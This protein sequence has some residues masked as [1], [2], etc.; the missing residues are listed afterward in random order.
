MVCKHGS[1]V[2]NDCVTHK[3]NKDITLRAH[4]CPISVVSVSVSIVLESTVLEHNLEGFCSHLLLQSFI[5]ANVYNTSTPPHFRGKV[6][7]T[8]T[9]KYYHYQFTLH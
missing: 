8:V 5:T 9:I 1:Q 2:V 4:I 3:G 6:F 7:R